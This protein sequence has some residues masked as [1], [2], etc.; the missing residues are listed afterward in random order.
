MARKTS[1]K[2]KAEGRDEQKVAQV[3]YKAK[4]QSHD[5]YGVNK[6]KKKK[7]LEIDVEKQNDEAKY[8]SRK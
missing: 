7:K 6:G 4:V 8:G 5:E 2:K 3:K 1:Q